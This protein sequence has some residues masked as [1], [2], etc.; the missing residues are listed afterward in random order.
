VNAP[1]A[2]ARTFLADLL[3]M[4]RAELALRLLAVALLFQPVGDRWVR[5]VAML[6]AAV[7]LLS[8][9]ALRSPWSWSVLALLAAVRIALVWP[10]SDNHAFLL[11]YWCLAAAVAAIAPDRDRVLAWN[12]RALVAGAFAF[13]TLWK[14]VLSPDFLDG[15]FFAVTLVGDPRFESFTLLATGMDRDELY[16]L[17]DLVRDHT[18]GVFVPWEEMPPPPPRL[19]AVARVMTA[20]TVALEAAIAVAFAAPLGPGVAWIRDAL[21]LV[22]CAGTY[23]LAPVAGFGW[24]LLSMG[25][26]QLDPARRAWRVAYLAVFALVL[27]ETRWPVF[28]TLLERL[29]P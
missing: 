5:P 26:A 11:A 12:G 17:R 27:V 16:D 10:V 23:A 15:R 25:I 13:A 1:R 29:G 7:V 14:L 18:D 28:A 8:P 21:L 20:A 9:R 19:F 3:E 6:V 22:F 4:E 2:R 24:L